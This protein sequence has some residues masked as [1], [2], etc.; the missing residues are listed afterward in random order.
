MAN[1]FEQ[2]HPVNNA[3]DKFGPAN[4]PSQPEPVDYG[5]DYAQPVEAV[6]KLISALPESDRQEANKQWAKNYVQRERKAGGIGQAV[7]D[8]ARNLA[9]GTIVGGWADEANALTQDML[10]NTGIGGSPYDEAL[11]YQR[12]T[13][14]AI[15]KD[16][17]VASTVTQMVGGAASGAPLFLKQYWCRDRAGRPIGDGR[18]TAWRWHGHGRCCTKDCSMEAGHAGGCCGQDHCTQDRSV[19]KFSPGDHQ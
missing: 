12:A 6:R 11:A 17:P 5:I 15:E 7:A 13:D 10:W 8:T 3:F 19:W 18:C 2:F 1:P 9:R 4:K 16:H 14:D